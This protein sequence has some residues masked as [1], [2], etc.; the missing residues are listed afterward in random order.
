MWRIWNL[1]KIF[2][3]HVSFL[4]FP[5]QWADTDY[6]RAYVTKGLISWFSEPCVTKHTLHK[7]TYEEPCILKPTMPTI[8]APWFL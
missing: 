3:F 2:I 8:N 7:I 4:T 1:D 5:R 6:R